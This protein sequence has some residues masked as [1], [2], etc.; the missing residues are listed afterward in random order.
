MAMFQRV[1]E[2]MSRERMDEADVKPEDIKSRR[3]R[4]CVSDDVV[5]LGRIELPS[6]N[7]S[8]QASPGA[9]YA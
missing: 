2:T 4:Y 3:R 8:A 7:K 1:I 6:E 5:E 9:G